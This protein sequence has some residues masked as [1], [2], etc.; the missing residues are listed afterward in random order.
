MTNDDTKY[1]EWWEKL[2]VELLEEPKADEDS[3]FAKLLCSAMLRRMLQIE[4]EAH[5]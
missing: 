3:L 5:K 4:N 2:K 1:R